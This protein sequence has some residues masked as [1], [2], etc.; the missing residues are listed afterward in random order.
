MTR[1]LLTTFVLLIFVAHASTSVEAQEWQSLVRGDSLEGWTKVGGDA[2]YAV[3]EGVITGK[4]GPGKNTFLTCG[5]FADFEL[6]FEVKC[7]PGLNSG[8]QIR[9]HLYPEDTPQE[10]NPK[11][12][13]EKG[14]MFGY[15]CE[16]RADIN[17]DHGCAGNF[18]DEGRRTRWL[19]EAVNAGEK[20][21]AYKPGE[22][23][24]MRII[25]KGNRIQSFVNGI[26]VADF[27]DDRD[28]EGILGLQVHSIKK[29]K[30]PFEVSWRKIRVRELK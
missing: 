26:A 28:A 8:V 2:T 25:A 27:V 21:P 24:R 29:G 17:G 18:W 14:E 20:Q 5:P 30:G 15:Q 10:S 19:D 6:E 12:I 7:D 13:R 16:I 22:W 9:S 3:K 11:R 4:T 1:L 23:N